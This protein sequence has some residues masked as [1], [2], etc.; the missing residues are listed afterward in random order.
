[1]HDTNSLNK[2]AATDVSTIPYFEPVKCPSGWYTKQSWCRADRSPQSYELV[3]LSAPN[4]MRSHQ[5]ITLPSKCPKEFDICS[6][7]GSNLYCTDTA[8]GSKIESDPTKSVE[9]KVT[10]DISSRTNSRD[11]I[12][13]NVML[14]DLDCNRPMYARSLSLS[15]TK[16]LG[17]ISNTASSSVISQVKCND[18]FN[19]AIAV[20]SN[21]E[22][23]SVQYTLA[24]GST[25]GLMFVP[26]FSHS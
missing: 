11:L 18:C 12:T 16:N 6:S 8:G 25:E 23:V 17:S 9:K 5:R 13:A 21:A 24:P 26:V 20:P 3:C 15:L 22:V 1:M 10:Q 4:R 7:S 2:R 14:T 19:L